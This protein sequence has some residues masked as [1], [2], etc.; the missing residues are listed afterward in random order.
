[1]DAFVHL[2]HIIL[3]KESLALFKENRR[4][5]RFDL[6]STVEEGLQ[7]LMGTQP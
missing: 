1:M 2:R 3:N 5:I 4:V 7:Q 6:K